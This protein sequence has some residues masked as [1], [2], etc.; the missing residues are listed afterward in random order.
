MGTKQSATAPPQNQKTK[1]IPAPSTA[2]ILAGFIPFLEKPAMSDP[3]PRL[4]RR[5]IHAHSRLAREVAALNYLLRVAKPAGTL[6]ENGRRSLND[7][8][9]AANKLYRHEPGLPSFR[10]IDPIN[11]L[12]NADIALM[13]TRLIV[14]CQAFEQRYAHLTD[15]ALPPMHA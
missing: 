8:M 11:P 7:V 5:A 15:A 4:G 12:T 13:V 9:R 1:N 3:L 14:A 10:L 6:G 2:A